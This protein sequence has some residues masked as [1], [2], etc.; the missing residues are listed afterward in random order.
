[1]VRITSL[2]NRRCVAFTPVVWS[3]YKRSL[4]GREWNDY[5]LIGNCMKEYYVIQVTSGGE[6]RTL[7]IIK[8][9]INNELI[10][11]AYI[12][13]MKKYKKYRGDWHTVEE[14]L[15]P[16]YIFI[17]TDNIRELYYDLQRVPKLTKILGIDGDVIYPLS[18]SEV[19]FIKSFCDNDEHTVDIS[20]G[21]IEGDKVIITD[22]PLLGKEA[23][24]RKI[25]RHKRIA[26]LDIDFFNQTIS[27]KVGLEIIKK[28]KNNEL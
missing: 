27:T 5:I 20:T 16:G 22:G 15:F 24:I 17:E 4:K 9:I 13:K 3:Y 25:D 21:F 8:E 14:I 18:D 23:H 26:Y 12:P 6:Y 28:D 1:M 19:Y 10:T 11:S 7:K 2:V